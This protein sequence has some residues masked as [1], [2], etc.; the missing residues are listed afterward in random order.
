VYVKGGDAGKSQPRMVATGADG[1]Q[2][3]V[4]GPLEINRTATY[5]FAV[6]QNTT[7]G[8]SVRLD[9]HGPLGTGGMV[10]C[11]RTVVYRR[12]STQCFVTG[13][14]CVS[15][16]TV[17]PN[18]GGVANGDV[19]YILDIKTLIHLNGDTS[20]AARRYTDWA[21]LVSLSLRLYRT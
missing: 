17:L 8:G 10:S 16:G 14:L 12:S 1:K 5:E 11:Q 15:T 2:A 21:H 19:F 9:C 20:P 6:P 13:G 3:L 18:F 7:Q 4:H